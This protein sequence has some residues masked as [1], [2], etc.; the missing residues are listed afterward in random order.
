M[1]H[2]RIFELYRAYPLTAGLDDVLGTVGD[3]HVTLRVDRRDVARLEPAVFR[4]RAATAL[5]LEV[6]AADPR[7]AHL[8]RTEGFAVPRQ[9]LAAIVDDAQFD[10]EDSAPRLCG[11][12]ELL[13]LRQPFEPG[14]ESI[15]GANRA[16]L[17]HTPTLAQLD[18]VLVAK[19]FDHCPRHGR[20]TDERSLQLVEPLAG[21]IRV[22]QERQPD[23]RHAERHRYVFA[24]HQFVKRLA[25]THFRARQHQLGAGNHCRVRNTP[26]IDVKERHD[27]Q[28]HVTARRPGDVDR[29]CREGVQNRRAMI[30]EDTL[31]I[32]RGTR[33]ITECRGRALIELR[34]VEFRRLCGQQR[35]V[36]H[37]VR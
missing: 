11:Q 9:L 29:Q 21:L 36:T 1:A 16:R 20:A 15:H 30:V 5:E 17:R 6:V 23:G 31:R 4:V 27:G 24:V 34:P 33:R 3:G 37:Y 12:V 14:F 19:R 32:S 10:T 2:C 8:Q 26:G 28:Q 13:V 22:L 18:A 25:V 35:L 7:S